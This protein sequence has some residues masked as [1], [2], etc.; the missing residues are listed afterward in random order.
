MS[1]G[2]I[3]II[4][5]GHAGVRAA[6]S[7]R[8]AGYKDGLT[9]LADEGVEA[10]YERPPLSKWGSEGVRAKALVPE[11]QLA[12]ADIHRIDARAI[13]LD[14]LTRT[15]TLEDGRTLRYNKLLL[16]TGASARRF[17][18]SVQN[19]ITVYDLRSHE[20]AVALAR[21]ARKARSAIIVG[22]GFI[23]LELA[24]SLR[25]LDVSV[26]V[27][28]AAD[29]LLSRAVTAPVA[30]IVH[31]LHDEK[32]VT[33]SVG[34]AL[35]AF[36][37]PNSVVLDDDTVLTADMLIA[38]IGSVPN[39]RLAQSAGLTVDNGIVVDSHLRTADPDIYAAG[40]C[41][42]F[43][44]YHPEGPMTRFESWQAAGEQGALAGRNMVADAEPETCSLVPW[45]WSEQYDHVLQVSG[46]PGSVSQTVE[47]HY[48][49]DHHVSFGVHSDGTLSFAC[50]IAPGTQIAKDIRFATKLIQAGAAVDPVQLGDPSIALKSL[51][52]R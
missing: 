46:I 2:E 29:R 16:A 15:I 7:M 37:N 5:A 31:R 47:R 28:E 1:G 39:T 48:F 32:G 33:F 41:C 25:A 49:P 50:G 45:F 24:A 13:K 3:L 40:D 51:L 36:L 11:E 4:G 30:A 9:L 43:P 6:L 8:G 10:P 26:H 27:V 38:G 17:P 19:G 35:K 44:L 52:R 12:D 14:R 42:S 20:E 18:E 21:A 22:G 23:G 34:K